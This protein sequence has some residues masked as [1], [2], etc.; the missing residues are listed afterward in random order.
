[1]GWA[2]WREANVD[3]AVTVELFDEMSSALIKQLPE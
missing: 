2:E 3:V 1:M